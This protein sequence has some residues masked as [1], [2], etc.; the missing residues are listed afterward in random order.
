[1]DA[2]I[3]TKRMWLRL[4]VRAVTTLMRGNVVSRL[5]VCSPQPLSFSASSFSKI[6]LAQ[7]TGILTLYAS[8][9][10]II[11]TAA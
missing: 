11:E 10:W 6:G 1:M 3:I 8:R 2:G 4:T 7:A 9:E 5:R